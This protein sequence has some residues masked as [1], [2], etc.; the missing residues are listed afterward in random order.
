MRNMAS[1]NIGLSLR[2][3]TTAQIASLIARFGPAGTQDANTIRT[4]TLIRNTSTDKVQVFDGLIF[5]DR[6]DIPD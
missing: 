1:R 5:V 3:Y 4:G 6:V 2:G